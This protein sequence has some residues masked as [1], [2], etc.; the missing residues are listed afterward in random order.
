[1]LIPAQIAVSAELLAGAGVA[2]TV[3][4]TALETANL[5]AQGVFLASILGAGGAQLVTTGTLTQQSST[6]N[7]STSPSDRLFV[8][9][10]SGSNL[11]YYVTRME[12]DFS[13]DATTFLERP[14]AFDY[15]VVVPTVGELSFEN[16]IPTGTCNFLVTARGSL[17]WGQVTYTVDLTL[18]GVYCIDTSFGYQ[19]LNDYTTTGT[20][21]APGYALTVNQ[22]WRHELVGGA[23]GDASSVEEWNNSTLTLGVDIFQW[24]NTKKQKSFRDGQPSSLDTYWLASG[25]VLRNGTTY[26]AYRLQPL[27]LLGLIK[28]VLDLPNETIDLEVWN[29]TP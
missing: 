12:G 29:V 10:Q 20:V 16:A 18:S 9:F 8:Q 2:Q 24:D 23:G 11:T 1:V 28:F 6:W 4:A 13:R 22:R 5:G 25:N 19:L 17:D 7:Y 27:P 14:H 15:R 26:G 21:T 3:G